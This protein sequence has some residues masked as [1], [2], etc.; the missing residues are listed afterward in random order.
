MA[1]AGSPVMNRRSYAGASKT[2][3]RS[4]TSSPLFKVMAAA[5]GLVALGMFT[6]ASMGASSST[7]QPWSNPL[8]QNKP[9]VY[10]QPFAE[11]PTIKK[12]LRTRHTPA[13]DAATGSVAVAAAAAEQ[14][15]ALLW[16]S[17]GLLDRFAPVRVSVACMLV[18]L[19]GLSAH[20]H[21]VEQIAGLDAML[22]PKEQVVVRT[23]LLAGLLGDDDRVLAATLD[24]CAATQSTLADS[25]GQV[26]GFFCAGRGAVVQLLTVLVCVWLCTTAVCD[27][28]MQRWL[29][30][31]RV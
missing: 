16:K 24:L 6:V 20:G 27:C 30:N 14:A 19:C 25:A 26:C 12:S 21:A 23:A 13:V 10:R 5:L 3:R 22:T 2:P 29:L 28:V 7:A 17:V 31:T 11:V 4:I 9:L 1:T 15:A 8:V 18:C